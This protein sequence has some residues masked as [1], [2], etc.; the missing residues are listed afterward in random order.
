VSTDALTIAQLQYR[1]RGSYAKKHYGDY[2][3]SLNASYSLNENFVAR[4]AFART[5]GR[6]SLNFII[7]TRSVADPAVAENNRVINTTNVG[8]EPW[9]ADNYDL[10]FESYSVKGATVAVSLFRKDISGFF[11][12][13]RTDAT[14]ELLA[15]MGLSD[16]YLDYDVISTRNSSDAVALSGVEWSWRQSLK[17]FAA[18]PK[19]SRGV[20]LWVNG[21]HLRLSGAGQDEFSGYAPRIL[22]W[23]AS[24]ASARF[25]LKYNVSRIGRQRSALDAVSATVPPGTYQAQDT[26]MVQDGSI[27]Y[28]FHR[29]F[30]VYASV[31]NLANE[32]RPLI[33][34]SAN[35][36]AYTRPSAYNFYGALWTIGVKGTF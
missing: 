19:W 23:G 17:P 15:E 34:Y 20:Q 7:P 21:T 32:P 12:A 1:E 22:N 2:Y 16:D 5:I 26:R 30:A 31:R 18:L 8:L 24:Y 3:P 11:V 25:L 36:P 6:P 10:S 13:T 29:K 27:E 14:P 28:R 4:A 33:T 9:T 35:A